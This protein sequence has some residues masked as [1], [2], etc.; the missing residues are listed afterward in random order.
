MQLRIRRWL[1]SLGLCA[2][3][4]LLAGCPKIEHDWDTSADFTRY[5][6]FTLKSGHALRKNRFE[7]MNSL[8]DE[9][10]LASVK[11]QLEAKG[12]REDSAHPDL[13]VTYL[14]RLER[15]RNVWTRTEPLYVYGYHYGPWGYW[16][17][18]YRRVMVS[19]YTERVLAVDL[20][21]TRRREL[22]WRAYITESG[23]PPRNPR[24]AE[25]GLASVMAKAFEKYPPPPPKK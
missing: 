6:T 3:A 18:R 21:D 12:L 13:I 22:V 24:K 17:P 4:L 25:E 11:R 10:V 16:G 5:K 20:N 8:Y 19:R 1:A 7:S 15:H 14:A 2:A 23:G 9:R